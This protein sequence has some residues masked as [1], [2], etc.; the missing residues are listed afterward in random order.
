MSD[1]RGLDEAIGLGAGPV[2]SRRGIL[3]R[4][5]TEIGRRLLASA[6]HADWVDAR[7]GNAKVPVL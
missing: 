4:T 3:A 6:F 7:P 2:R 5:A 1:Q